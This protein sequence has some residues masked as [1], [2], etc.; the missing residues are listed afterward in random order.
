MSYGLAGNGNPEVLDQDEEQDGQQT[1]VIERSG[2]GVEEAGQR[3]AAR[4][5]VHD[6]LT[7]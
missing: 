7:C 5:G 1:V 6:H 4:Q 2:Q 3:T